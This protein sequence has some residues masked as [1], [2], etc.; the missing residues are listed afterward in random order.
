M[1][2]FVKTCVDFGVAHLSVHPY[3]SEIPVHEFLPYPRS[4][5]D[6]HQEKILQINILS[7]FLADT[8]FHFQ[9]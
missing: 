5:P 8:E 6:L 1:Q 2:T 3:G 9:N 4:N 7:C